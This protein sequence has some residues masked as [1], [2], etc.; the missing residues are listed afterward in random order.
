[1]V[2]LAL[3]AGASAPGPRFGTHGWAGYAWH[4]G[5]HL[6]T[7]SLRL[8]SV[9]PAPNAGAAFWA[10]FGTGPGV[11]QAGFTANMVGGHLR[12]TAWSELY[13]SP[14]VGFGQ[15]AYSGDYVT[16]TV[17]YRGGGWFVLT[18]RDATRHWTAT[19]ARR[20]RVTTLGTA[21]AIVEAY[22]PPLA[23]FAPARFDHV[24]AGSRAWAYGLRG[25]NVTPLRQGTFTVHS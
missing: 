10:G 8:P 1:M 5:S 15:A 3:P 6:V 20:A 13:P 16:M 9:S 19:A 11:E 12:W 18:V 17:T 22:G 23:R 24:S 25:A 2:G 7:A 4:T 14:P 21:E